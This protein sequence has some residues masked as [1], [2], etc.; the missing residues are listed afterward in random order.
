MVTGTAAEEARAAA[1]EIMAVETTEEIWDVAA[2]AG[3]KAGM[4]A[5]RMGAAD[6]RET[7]RGREAASGR[8]AA[9][10]MERETA[11]EEKRKAAPAARQGRTAAPVRVAARSQGSGRS[12]FPDPF[13]PLQTGLCAAAKNS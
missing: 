1:V 12:L 8:A 7:V 9:A 2:P 3:G 10:R 4:T 13:R 6:E 11:K 5:V